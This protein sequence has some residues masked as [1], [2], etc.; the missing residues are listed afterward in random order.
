MCTSSLSS[1][2]SLLSGVHVIAD[3]VQH[4]LQALTSTLLDYGG[5]EPT[6]FKI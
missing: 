3:L 1:P 5:R 4:D 6:C 2:A